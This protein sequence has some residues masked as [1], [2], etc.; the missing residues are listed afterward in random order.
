[1][2]RY[3]FEIEKTRSKYHVF[4]NRCIIH[5]PSKKKEKQILTLPCHFT[6]EPS[7]TQKLNV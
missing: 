5:T 7:G 2:K 6:L 4:R 1:M 3:Y